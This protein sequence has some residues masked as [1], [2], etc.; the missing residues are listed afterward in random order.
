MP[1]HVDPAVDPGDRP[2]R[3]RCA[4]GSASGC[5]RPRCRSRTSR[6]RPASACAA[7]RDRL[8]VV[9]RRSAWLACAIAW[10][11]GG[12]VIQCAACGWSSTTSRAAAAGSVRSFPP[13]TRV[14]F[15]RHPGVRGRRSTRTATSTRARATPSCAPLDAGLGARRPRQLE[16]H[17]RR[18]PP[19]SP[20]RRSR[21]TRR[22]RSSSD[23]A[24]RACG[25]SSATTPR[26]RRCRPRRSERPAAPRWVIPRSSAVAILRRRCWCSLLTHAS[27]RIRGNVACEPRIFCENSRGMNC[28]S[29]NSPLEPNARFCGVC[30]YRL[31]ARVA[32]PAASAACPS[33][34]TGRGAHAAPRRP[35]AQRTQPRRKPQKPRPRRSARAE[36]RRDLHRPDAQQSLQGRVEDRRGRV[37]RGVSRRAARDRTQGRAQAPA[38]GDDE[39][40]EPRR[41]VPP[42]GHG[43]LQP[44]R[45]AHDHDVRLRSDARRHALHRDG[46]ARGQ[47]PAPDLPRAGAARVEARCSRS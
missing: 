32:L 8:V 6:A 19:R 47:E 27:R 43:A 7:C 41:A 34:D 15:G 14:R 1:T 20:R 2:A 22:S 21:R 12:Q 3:R 37:R 36:G 30:G 17:L 11:L 38:P 44:A 5:R 31:A 40:R 13:A 35:Q 10:W 26:S 4:R 24:A 9:R 28:P 23:P 25:C 45:R 39:G 16:R 46:A 18:G 29:C 42:R 33:R